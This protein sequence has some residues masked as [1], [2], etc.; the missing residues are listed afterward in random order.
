MSIP[1]DRSA[2]FDA[3]RRYNE[4][5]WPAQ[6]LLVVLAAVAVWMVATRS[7]S[8]RLTAAILGWFWLWMA[9]AYHLLVFT[10]L[11]PA[12][13]PF[14]ALFVAESVMLAY[15]GAFRRRL[16]FGIPAGR[17]RR[18]AGLGMIVYAAL[19]YPALGLLVGHVPPAAPTFG[20]PCPTTIF[21]LGLLL[22]TT[23]EPPLRLLVVPAAWSIIA[24]GAAVQFGMVE[25]Y[26]LP[27]SA[28]LTF[29]ILLHDRRTHRR[30]D[31]LLPLV[32]H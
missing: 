29:G 19:I 1:F 30:S 25:D 32:L 23:D 22:W 16:A 11:S 17:M 2:F 12:G 9:V 6:L 5:V 10:A 3:F 20:L 18:L 7:G 4:L 15:D 31:R 26:A 28:V 24:L 13:Y 27:V 8:P 21:T 14:A